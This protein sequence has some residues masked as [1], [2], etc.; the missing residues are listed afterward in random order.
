MQYEGTS[1]LTRPA[2]P[3]CRRTCPLTSPPPLSDAYSTLLPGFLRTVQRLSSRG[4]RIRVDDG[5]D[6]I[7]GFF[8]DEWEGVARRFDSSRGDFE[9]YAFQAFYRYAVR[10]LAREARYRARLVAPE[11]LEQLAAMP[12]DEASV[13]ASRLR[14]AIDALPSQAAEVL[15]RFVHTGSARAAAAELG[16]GRYRFHTLLAEAVAEVALSLGPPP[17]V[18]PEDWTTTELVLRGRTVRQAARA[19]GLPVA[20]VRASYART[21]RKLLGSLFA[22]FH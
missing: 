13:D 21:L 16:L 5:R 11:V 9:P 10:Q 1:G 2:P 20:D 4:Y 22:W 3:Q 7:Q 12:Y 18:D 6:L 8:A 14:S 17:H 19:R 15:Q